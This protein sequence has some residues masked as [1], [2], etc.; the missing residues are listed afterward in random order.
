MNSSEKPRR[1]ENGKF[2]RF[3]CGLTPVTPQSDLAAARSS[4]NTLRCL[5]CTGMWPPAAAEMARNRLGLAIGGQG[6]KSAALPSARSSLR[7]P[8]SDWDWARALQ[9][10][11][12]AVLLLRLIDFAPVGSHPQRGSGA[13]SHSQD[14]QFSRSPIRIGLSLCRLHGEA[15]TVHSPVAAPAGVLRQ[16]SVIIGDYCGFEGW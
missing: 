12:I 3:G 9:R 13:E 6:R 8:F 16:F 7:Y 4:A 11:R 1:N 15:A 5:R 2:E 14:F 10:R